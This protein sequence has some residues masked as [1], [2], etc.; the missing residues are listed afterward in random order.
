MDRKE[1]PH[2][3]C[4][5]GVLRSLKPY[6]RWVIEHVTFILAAVIIGAGAGGVGNFLEIKVLTNYL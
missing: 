5:C 1:E 2:C 6:K 3:I 4:P